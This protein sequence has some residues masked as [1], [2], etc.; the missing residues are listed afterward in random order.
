[1]EWNENE[2][3][4]MCR[5]GMNGND[6]KISFCPALFKTDITRKAANAIELR[7]KVND[8][9]EIAKYMLGAWAF[10]CMPAADR[11]VA[12]IDAAASMPDSM[13]KLVNDIVTQNQ[14]GVAVNADDGEG[15]IDIGADDDVSMRTPARRTVQRSSAPNSGSSLRD[16]P[17][18]GDRSRK[19]SFRHVRFSDG[20]HDESMRER[21]SA[22]ASS[23]SAAH[24]S[25]SLSQENGFRTQYDDDM[26]EEE[27]I[28]SIPGTNDASSIDSADVQP[29][30]PAFTPS[31]E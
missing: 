3:K 16:T 10:E 11:A 4:K 6:C 15:D 14:K 13:L 1:M 31:T 5:N 27:E 2:W 24:A 8:T 12:K 29:A 7:K 18:R 28:V 22:S 19:R 30:Q 26:A 21:E 17:H 20:E 25:T 9:N 23:A